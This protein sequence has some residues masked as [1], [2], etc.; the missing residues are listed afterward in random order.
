[1]SLT[2][3]YNKVKSGSKLRPTL[4]SVNDE[5]GLS[6]EN[7]A[8]ICRCWAEN[9]QDR[10]DFHSIRTSIRKSFRDGDTGN[11]LDNLLRRMEQYANNLESLVEDRTRAY[12]EEKKKAEDL[13]YA[14]LPK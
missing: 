12:L 9:P 11:I 1:M 10:P 13:L 4:D 6:K 3:I 8:Y 14:M 2:E 7:M 5:E